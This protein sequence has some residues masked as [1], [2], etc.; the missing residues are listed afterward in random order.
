MPGSSRKKEEKRDAP[1]KVFLEKILK[2]EIDPKK[3][4]VEE[5]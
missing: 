4:L 2:S 5:N 1:S 3:S